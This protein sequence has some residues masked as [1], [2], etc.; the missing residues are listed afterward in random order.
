MVMYNR[1]LFQRGR[2]TG[3]VAGE[4]AAEAVNN[5]NDRNGDTSGD[6]TVFDGGRAGFVLHKAGNEVL[7]IKLHVCTWLVE[8]T[9]GLAGVLSTVTVGNGTVR[10]LRHS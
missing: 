5:G 9:F 7:H 8:L 3:E 2:D 1:R 6:Q 10:R 4:L